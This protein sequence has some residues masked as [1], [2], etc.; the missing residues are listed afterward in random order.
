MGLGFEALF[1]WSILP[2]S[3]IYHIKN[4]I[5]GVKR[6][7]FHD[8]NICLCDSKLGMHHIR[9]LNL[10]IESLLLCLL[11]PKVLNDYPSFQAHKVYD[12]RTVM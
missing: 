1:L 4:H 3:N 12:F 6:S 11:T 2:K 5:L 7:V 8:P 10:I 9:N